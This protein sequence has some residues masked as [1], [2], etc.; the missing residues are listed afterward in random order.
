[1]RELK[2]SYFRFAM[3]QSLANSDYFRGLTITK[4]KMEEF[5]RMSA[6]SNEERAAIEAADTMDFA[7]Y[8]QHF[9]NH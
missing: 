1:M 7:A 5:T 8:L 9:N 3:N 6:S 2:T 4:D